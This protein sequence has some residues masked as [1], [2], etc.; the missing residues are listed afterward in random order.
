MTEQ[1]ET[2]PGGPDVVR[3]GCACPVIDNRHGKGMRGLGLRYVIDDG[4]PFHHFPTDSEVECIVA[5]AYKRDD[6][7]WALPQ[8][9]RHHNVM[10]FWRQATG[11]TYSPYHE[12]GFLTSKG[13]FVD[14]VESRALAIA[15]GQVVD[16]DVLHHDQ[17]FSEDLW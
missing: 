10:Q 13:R 8:P 6:E 11:N 15:A 12:Q 16:D 14:R 3:R 17:L 7:V 9:A 2:M 5:V 1:C 4:C